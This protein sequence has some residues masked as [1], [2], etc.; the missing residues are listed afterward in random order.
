MLLIKGEIEH[1]YATTKPKIV[2]CD[3]A[4]YPVVE[5][6]LK[7]IGLTSTIYIINGHVENVPHVTEFLERDDDF[8]DDFV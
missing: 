7:K 4:V 1:M 8:L 6:A 3:E 5:S 2:F